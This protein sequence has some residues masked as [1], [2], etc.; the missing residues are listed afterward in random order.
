MSNLETLAYFAAMPDAVNLF[1]L[2][3]SLIVFVICTLLP[4]HTARQSTHPATKSER[5]MHYIMH[6]GTA[7]LV[8]SF[9]ALYFTH[10]QLSFIGLA[11]IL[12]GSVAWGVFWS[13]TC[14]RAMPSTVAEGL[15]RLDRQLHQN[16]H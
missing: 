2:G 6:T 8:L 15:A 5:H 1:C 11:L 12:A 14:L 10:N 4:H 9:G 7:L 3:L 13:R 16:D